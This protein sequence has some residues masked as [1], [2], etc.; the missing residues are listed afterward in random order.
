MVNKENNNEPM[1]EETSDEVLLEETSG[2]ETLLEE[3]ADTETF[4]EERKESEVLLEESSDDEVILE[5]STDP[6]TLLKDADEKD[7][8]VEEESNNFKAKSA[9]HEVKKQIEETPKSKYR[10]ILACLSLIVLIFA[11]LLVSS[12]IKSCQEERETELFLA[13]TNVSDVSDEFESTGDVETQMAKAQ[14]EAETQMSSIPNLG[15]DVLETL[16]SKYDY[17]YSLSDGFYRINHNGK[18]GLADAQGQVV[19]KPIYDYMSSKDAE[20][21]LIMVSIN[22]KYGFL[23]ARGQVVVEPIY[24]YMSSK[25]AETG[26][27]RVSINGKYG[28]LNAR[29]QV[30]IKPIYDYMSSKDGGLYKVRIGN[31]TGYLNKDG[32]VFKVPE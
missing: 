27:I 19:V 3:S 16:K 32:S 28:F 13:S 15:K 6:E 26:L 29:G 7:G 24:D 30:V 14:A 17:V 21:G 4:L 25:D 2:E 20:T 5:E 10:I 8:I 23:N 22:G 31:K 12:S 18:Y 9:T 1:L 11:Y